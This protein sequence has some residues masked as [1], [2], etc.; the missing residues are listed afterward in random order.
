M[1]NAAAYYTGKVEYEYKEEY[2]GSKTSVNGL[3]VTVIIFG[4]AVSK[5][6]VALIFCQTAQEGGTSRR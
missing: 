3:T 6:K 5:I 1:Q 4:A 2:C